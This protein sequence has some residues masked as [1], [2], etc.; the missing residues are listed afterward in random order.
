MRAAP[1]L[2]RPRVLLTARYATLVAAAVVFLFPYLWMFAASFRPVQE[3]FQYIYPLSWKTFVPTRLSLEG[4][5]MLFTAEPFGRYIFNT[6]F[7]AAS[8]TLLDMFISSLAAYAFARIAFPGRDLIFFTLLSTMIIPFEAVM[9]PLYLIV[10][11]FGWIDTYQVLIVPSVGRIF[12]IFLLRQF[13]LGIPRDLEDAARIDGCNHWG[14]YRH[15]VLPLTAPAL[16][17]LGII[18][19]HESWDSFIWPLIATNR[20]ELRL[21]Q[22]AIATFSQ[23]VILWDRIFAASSIATIL[24][25]LL[26]L[27]FQRYYVRGITTTG[28][29]G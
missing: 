11:A 1:A 24:P 15:V 12:S 26:F 25:I 20:Q 14:I 18:T 19:F 17:S 4:Y 8:V 10:R 28:L 22:V 3:I 21:I 2:S 9:I 23:E 16:I 7:V 29:K 6:I 27:A 5:Q 13:M